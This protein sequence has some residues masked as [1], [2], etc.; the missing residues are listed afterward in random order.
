MSKALVG[1]EYIFSLDIGTRSVIGTISKF[2]GESLQIVDECYVEHHVRSMIDGQIHDIHKVSEAVKEVVSSL[3]KNNSIKLSGV[4]IAAAGR[5]LR[6]NLVKYEIELEKDIEITKDVVKS[7]ELGAVQ[8]AERNI[9]K[10][11]EG[12]LYCVGHSV[13]AYYL[14]GFLISNLLGHR[15]EKAEIEMI[16]TFLPRS[17]V[18]SLYKVIEMVGLNVTHMTLEPIAAM[19]AVLP[20]KLRLLNIALVDIGAGTS[21]IAISADNTVKAFGMVPMAGDEVSEV[22]AQSYLTD[23]NT[24]ESI[25]RQI[26]DNET[27][28]YVDVLGFENELSKEEILKII[29]PTI[30]KIAREIATKILELNGE[31]APS[32]VFL[33][34]GGANTPLLKEL[35]CERL[36]LPLQRIGIKDRMSV[37]DYIIEENKMGSIGV[38]VLGIA[39]SAIR[40]SGKDFITVSL[41]GKVISLFNSSNAKVLDVLIHGGID[42]SK[43]IGK[44]GKTLRFTL[45]DIERIAMGTMPKNSQII[46]NNEVGNI[47]SPVKDGDILEVTL[48]QDGKDGRA[49][50][51]DYLREV[52]E[53]TFYIDD[54]IVNMHPIAIKN[55]EVC[56]IDE[57]IQENDNIKIIYPKNVGDIRRYFISFEKILHKNGI[58]LEEDY[59]IK[60][61]DVLYTQ[62]DNIDE[63]YH[64]PKEN[65]QEEKNEH[66]A[67][68]EKSV[69]SDVTVNVNGENI[70]LKGKEKY[71]FVDIF[72]YI[73]FDLTMPKGNLV[74]KLNE[75]STGYQQ[76]I[77]N[78]DV[79]KIYWDER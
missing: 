29:G 78:G 52:V 50:I 62:N 38:T 58:L 20:E 30:E 43:L 45:N 51:L 46:I 72:D 61:G 21:D 27:I 19:E 41:N 40:S 16:C 47:D 77:K 66:K 10:T 56:T 1:R 31:K 35:I 2:V 53:V 57:E 25:K 6:T 60:Q 55:G 79:I 49:K 24:A 3:E 64:T 5:F 8:E 65:I 71:I 7:L 73:N 34:G 11:S 36:N 18:E 33:I 15:G 14:N 17:V 26:N 67:S 37:S 39:L 68:E 13:K 44:K 70:T 59:E 75:N 28:K 22:I 74:V 48:A 63:K 12:K 54:E 42:S 76:E 23:F 69:E 32:A 4:S 9:G